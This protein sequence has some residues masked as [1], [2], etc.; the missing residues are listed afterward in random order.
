VTVPPTFWDRVSADYDRQ[1][2]LERGPVRC[3]L[4]LLAPQDGE[5]ILDVGTGTGEVL[6]QLARRRSRLQATGVDQ[7]AAML[8]R[9]PE[10]PAGWSVSVADARRLP[11]ADGAF[12][13][14]TA[15]YL[16]HVLPTKDI[17]AVA[18]ELLRVLRPGGRLVTITP[19]IPPRGPLRLLGSALDGLARRRPSRYS[20]LRALDPRG[21]LEQAGFEI[22]AARWSLRGYLSLCIL[23]RRPG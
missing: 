4:A 13:A 12:D 3:A 10:L 11:Y 14:V 7:S 19:A 5:R 22:A 6:R 8:A 21:S 1:L 15:A 16:L 2:F 9:V 23:A 20:G 18:G 17:P